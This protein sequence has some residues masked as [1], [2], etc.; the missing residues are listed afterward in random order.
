[1][2]LIKPRAG[3]RNADETTVRPPV[4]THDSR[5]SS[6]HRVFWASDRNLWKLAIVFET[7]SMGFSLDLSSIDTAF[8]P[9]PLL[10]DV[11]SPK[12]LLTVS[13]SLFSTLMFCPSLPSTNL[14]SPI[15]SKAA[16]VFH[17]SLTLKET[18][19][20][21]SAATSVLSRHRQEDCSFSRCHMCWS[22]HPSACDFR[23]ITSIPHWTT[24]YTRAG[25]KFR[26][27]LKVFFLD[28][29]RCDIRSF[30]PDVGVFPSQVVVD[31][32]SHDVT[33]II[34]QNLLKLSES[35]TVIVHH[36]M[37]FQ[38]FPEMDS[39]RSQFRHVWFQHAA[40][41]R[42]RLSSWYHPGSHHV[43]KIFQN[44]LSTVFQHD[45]QTRYNSVSGASHKILFRFHQTPVGEMCCGMHAG[46]F[47]K[48][49]DL[50][51]EVDVCVPVGVGVLVID[52]TL[53]HE[54]K[55]TTYFGRYM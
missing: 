53:I 52:E 55:K 1:M 51:L 43:C 6:T 44:P 10:W 36:H 19:A 23:K 8:L 34:E 26:F 45:C 33:I 41:V 42:C 29:V 50:P 16:N 17:I 25:L 20:A 46:F 7:E 39:H 31:L 24:S 54:K 18:F 11:S 32:T 47:P 21:V 2:E 9:I 22:L 15:L 48:R 38:N 30:L 5:L 12:S 3:I 28:Q 37:A 40:H 35:W 49:Y 4:P 27:A 14:R 13:K